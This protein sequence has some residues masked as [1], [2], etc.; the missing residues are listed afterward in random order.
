MPE[1]QDRARPLRKAEFGRFVAR[2]R[3]PG[4]GR[5]YRQ[6]DDL[7]DGFAEAAAWPE[8]ARRWFAR[9]VEVETARRSGFH[10]LPV[11]LIAGAAAV[12][13]V[14][15]RPDLIATLVAAALLTLLGLRAAALPPLR[16]A[17]FGLAGVLCGALLATGEAETTGTTII[18]GT[19]TTRIA[20]TVIGA[21]RDE[22][23]RMRYLVA[24]TGTTRPV[25]SRPPQRARILVSARHDE[26]APGDPFYGLVR[27]GPPSGPAAPGSHD[28]AYQPYFDG[29]GALGFALGAP[30]EAPT[31]G[32]TPPPLPN[33]SGRLAIGL[34]R[35]RT[36]MTARITEA[37]GGGEAGAIAAALVT[38]ERAGISDDA[39]TW[40]RGVGLAHVLSISGLH[41]A[42]VAGSALLLLRGCLALFPA[43]ALNYPVKKIAALAALLV[44]ALY[45]FLSGSNVATERAFVMLA[46]MLAAV[47]ADRPAI[48]LRN[49]SIAALVVVAV[50]P[51]AV[52]TASFQMSFAATLALVA[53]YGAF[54]RWRGGRPQRADRPLFQQAA[55][56]VGATI[57]GIVASSIIAGTATA[58]FAAYHFH[59][60]APFGLVA[61]VLTLPLFT[62][63]IMPLGL[64]GSLL[65]PFGLDAWCFR[66]M[67]WALDLVL[68]ISERLYEL[69]PDRGTGPIAGSGVVLLAAALLAVAYF[70]SQFRWIAAPLALAGLLAIRDTG[71]MPQLLVYEDG[72]T[73]AAF[74]GDGTLAL[75]GERPKRFV[76]DQWERSTGVDLML[77]VSPLAPNVPLTPDGAPAPDAAGEPSEGAAAGDLSR[78]DRSQAEPRLPGADEAAG[79][80]E[81][82]PRRATS[83]AGGRSPVSAE[84]SGAGQLRRIVPACDTDFCRFETRDGLRIVWTS[85]YERT[86]EACDGGDVAIVARAI[87]LTECQSGAL[88]VTL[89]TLRRTGSLAILRD[90]DT[91]RAVAV[92]SVAADRQAWNRHRLAPWPEYW[93][94]PAENPGHA[95]KGRRRSQGFAAS[96]K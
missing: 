34:E 47:I 13:A 91:G 48:T 21:S 65:M 1:G 6:D 41:L 58:P 37:A 24:I 31:E 23:G 85:D 9:Q 63:I 27:L 93:R 79:P 50:S 7:D 11:S 54:A 80:S 35:I 16:A 42:I 55:R 18:S 68:L 73:I 10:V 32:L 45:L 64:I 89:R 17:L 5:A 25:L 8:R 26:R 51:H 43:L 87:R 88:L 12:F 57:L 94:K 70:A 86:G 62:L 71:A 61:N 33:L 28:F 53:G 2:L 49:V 60:V 72:K 83:A 92:P 39:E 81:S 52:T 84:I 74:A 4:N 56:L 66:L 3:G 40:L 67:G 36:A 75:L 95:E 46:V 19:A 90:G 30:D 20:G 69:L 76:T 22:K 38:G 44:A 14:D 15:W 96:P 59:R 29:V 77:P 78:A 82:E